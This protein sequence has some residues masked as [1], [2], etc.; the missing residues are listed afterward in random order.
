MSLRLTGLALIEAVAAVAVV[1]VVVAV[2]RPSKGK[3][4]AVDPRNGFPVQDP[5]IT[6][7]IDSGGWPAGSSRWGC[8]SPAMRSIT[9]MKKFGFML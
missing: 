6:G 7:S 8:C 5:P 4:E 3:R 9:V 2:V 1:V